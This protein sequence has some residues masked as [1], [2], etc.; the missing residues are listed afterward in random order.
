MHAKTRDAVFAIG[1]AGVSGGVATRLIALG[2]RPISVNDPQ[3]AA[4]RLGREPAPVRAALVP[5]DAPFL[6]PGSLFRL[7]RAAGPNSLRCVALG[8]REDEAHAERLRLAGVST[9]L[10]DPYTDRELRFAVNRALHDEATGQSRLQPR[11]ATDLV[12]RIRLGAREKA[13]L[14]YS[15]SA[16]GCFVE[17]ERPCVPE[18]HVSVNVPLP[19]GAIEL[20]ARVMWV[21]VP[22]DFSRSNLPRGMALSFLDAR[23]EQRAALAAFVSEQL[24]QQGIAARG[25]AAVESSGMTRVWS[26]LRGL[27]ASPR[28]RSANA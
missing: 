19:S 15:L 27:I 22:G 4:A 26:R 9:T 18:S 1:F 28:E 25:D 17:T 21:N 3:A 20:A 5:A 23:A 16:L 8:R 6:T 14:V 2:Y 11:T 10:W 7:V 24:A 12:A 13:G